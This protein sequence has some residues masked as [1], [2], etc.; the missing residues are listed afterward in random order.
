[1]LFLTTV[2]FAVFI[3]IDETMNPIHMFLL[4]I[5]IFVYLCTENTIVF[6]LP[7]I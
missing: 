2:M 6:F 1:M 5:Y 7:E 3:E 4:R